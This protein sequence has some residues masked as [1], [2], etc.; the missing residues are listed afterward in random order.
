MVLVVN[1]SKLVS[2]EKLPYPINNRYDL[3][4]ALK[5]YRV[6]TLICGG[7]SVETK[8]AIESTGVTIVAN[9]ACSLEEAVGALQG[10]TMRPGYGLSDGKANAEESEAERAPLIRRSRD[11]APV[12]SAREGRIKSTDQFSVDCFACEERR[13]LTK[14]QCGLMAAGK[15]DENREF[16][17]ILEAATDISFEPER[18]LCRV[19]E[20]IYFA[21][22][23]EY[24]KVGIAFCV[25]LFEQAGILAKVLERYFEVFSVCCRIGRDYVDRPPENADSDIPHFEADNVLCN[26]VGQAEILNRFG[27]D[28]NILAGL[29]VGMD[30]VFTEVSQAPVTALFVKDKMLANNPIGAVYSEFYLDEI[31]KQGLGENR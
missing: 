30:C 3:L 28:I 5:S 24:K 8:D 13:C 15:Q 4:A 22:E 16:Q 7:N 12:E 10:G 27:S 23:M 25:D 2:R 18:A 31:A 1:G 19:A 17:R 26:P 9:V 11:P 20:F 14:H 21:L 29:S 6:D